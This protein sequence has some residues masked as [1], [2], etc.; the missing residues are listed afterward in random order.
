MKPRT[1]FQIK[2]IVVE[3]SFWA[4]AVAITKLS[5]SLLIALPISLFNILF[6]GPY[7]IEKFPITKTENKNP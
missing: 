2:A 4:S 7:I 6:L 3:L 5:Y 1:I